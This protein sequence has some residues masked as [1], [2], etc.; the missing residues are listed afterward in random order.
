M[1]ALDRY[2][3]AMLD[4]EDNYDTMDIA[5]RRGAEEAMR[6]RDREQGLLRR[7]DQ[8]LFYEKEDDEDV[9]LIL[10]L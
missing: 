8:G 3:P 10:Y 9:G 4:E 1:P 7:D 6:R 5:Q 2:D